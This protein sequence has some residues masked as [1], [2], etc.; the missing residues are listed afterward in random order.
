M[1]TVDASVW[2]N[3]F[4]QRE[5]GHE[6]SRQ[7]LDLLGKQVIPVFVPNLILS[8]V[9]GAISR[10]RNNPSQAEAFAI[11]L[12]K[13]PN[14]TVIP[15]DNPLAHQAFILAARHGLRGA[16]AVYAAVATQRG[17]TLISLD[18]EHLT[19]LIGIVKTQT[20]TTALADLAQSST[21]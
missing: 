19:R 1:Y 10:T 13:L 15:L 3:G 2:V 4:D 8:E 17:C 5:P 9:A 14:V 6:I 21:S 16:D 7:F 18:N 12:S 11:L 20:P